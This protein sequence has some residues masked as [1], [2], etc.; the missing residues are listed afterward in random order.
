LRRSVAS[1]P[2]AGGA[3]GAREPRFA[4]PPRR[5]AP[6]VRRRPRSVAA[7][8]L[9]TVA[10]R[11]QGPLGAMGPSACARSCLF[12]HR[13]VAKNRALHA[14]RPPNAR[15][16][17]LPFPRRHHFQSQLF[18]S[19]RAAW[20]GMTC[21]SRPGA[22]RHSLNRLTIFVLWPRR[23]LELG[24]DRDQNL[25]PLTPSQGAEYL[26]RVLWGIVPP[27]GRSPAEAPRATRRKTVR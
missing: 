25:F 20:P 23:P 10:A 12:A 11:H 2:A 6:R 14:K 5:G 18:A 24:S 13:N 9:V 22:K 3:A 26:P 17:V 1:W 21:A 7:L 27:C 15:E 16:T 8:A 19:R 4:H